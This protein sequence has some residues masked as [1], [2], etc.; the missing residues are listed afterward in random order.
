M[1][2]VRSERPPVDPAP[3]A[4][5]DG[6]AP[7]LDS[8]PPV[9]LPTWQPSGTAGPSRSWVAQALTGLGL[10][11]LVTIHMI[12]NHFI[13]PEGLRDF[14]AVV[15]YLSHPVIVAIEV[16]FLVVVTWHGLLGVRAILF[17]FGFSPTT[18]RRISRALAVL[19]VATVAY[20]LWLTW[21]VVSYR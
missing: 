9:E 1:S 5:R 13:V 7:A 19:G 21:V 18:E 11:A 4:P 8:Q 14:A 3:S 6:E 16:T 17:D 10:L 12:A 15:D 2:D 20:G